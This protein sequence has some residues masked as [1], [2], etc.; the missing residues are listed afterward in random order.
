MLIG[1]DR[2]FY[3]D[4]KASFRFKIGDCGFIDTDN[5]IR[6]KFTA[7]MMF[8]SA[9]DCDTDIARKTFRCEAAGI[10]FLDG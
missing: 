3:M 4:R 10:D 5:Q 1:P 7:S 2:L 9:T 6:G 8:R